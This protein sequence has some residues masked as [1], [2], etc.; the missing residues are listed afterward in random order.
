MVVKMPTKNELIKHITK[1]EE[2]LTQLKEGVE[3]MESQPVSLGGKFP[4]LSSIDPALIDESET[5][6]EKEFKAELNDSS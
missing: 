4:E 3:N 2:E 6:L 5:L 1:L